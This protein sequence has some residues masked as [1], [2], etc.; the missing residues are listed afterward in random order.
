MK[1][2]MSFIFVS[3]VCVIGCSAE[4]GSSAGAPSD[5]AEPTEQTSQPLIGAQ[6]VVLNNRSPPCKNHLIL[7]ETH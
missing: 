5:P 2:L 4:P 3:L 1:S 7:S 6:T